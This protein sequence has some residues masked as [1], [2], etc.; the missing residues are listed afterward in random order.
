MRKVILKPGRE[1]SLLRRHPWVFS[2]AIARIDGKA[3]AGET[4][5]VVA[6]D[7]RFLAVAAVNPDA[8]ITARVWDWNEG[9]QIDA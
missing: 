3:V 4:A 8:N 9:T 5:H 2:G 6:S 1:K 7:G